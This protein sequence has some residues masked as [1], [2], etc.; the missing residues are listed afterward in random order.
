MHLR[1]GRGGHVSV[2]RR[3][4][5]RIPDHESSGLEGRVVADDHHSLKVW[6]RLLSCST[7]VETTIRKRLRQH[8]GITLARF[9][10]MAQLHRHPD[11]LAMSVLSRYLM[12]TG[13]NVTGLADEL[14]KEGLVERFADPN[15]GRSSRVSLTRK[16]RRLFDKLAATHEAWIVSM[17]GGMSAADMRLLHELLGRLR[18]QLTASEARSAPAVPETPPITTRRRRRSGALT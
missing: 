3:P 2:S 12:V 14:E 18:G 5:T 4:R 8:A 16:G 6:L 7:Q 13:G 11:G 9:D 10:F 1:L 15:D 17:F